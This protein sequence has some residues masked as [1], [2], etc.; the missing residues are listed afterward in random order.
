MEITAQPILSTYTIISRGAAAGSYQAF[1]DA[2]RL[3]NGDIVVVYYAGYT[4]V[5]LPNEEYPRGG[6]ICMVRSQDEGQSW[7]EPEVLYDDEADNRDPHI[8]QLQDGTVICSFFSLRAEP[9]A[10]Y[11]FA[12]LGVQVVRS[13]D[14]GHTWEKNAPLLETENGIWVCSCPVRQLAVGTCLLPIY[15]HIGE[16]AWGG[17]LRSEDGGKTWGKEITIGKE[18]QILMPAETD[19]IELKDG[20][21]Y[22]ALRADQ[23]VGIEMQ[24]SVSVD[25]GLTWSAVQP[26]GFF[27]HAPHFSRLRNG[28]I[29]LTTRG[30]HKAGDVAGYTALQIS[31]DEAHSWHGPYL[32]DPSPGAYTATVELKDGGILIVYYEEGEGSGIRAAR[33]RID[34]NLQP[35]GV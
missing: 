18:A 19:I 15:Q 13:F 33:F 27:G 35:V 9:S 1:P 3:Q 26:I 22:A 4:H 25:R 6:R 28:H 11:G 31:D 2:C 5:S 16:A 30:F 23:E 24:Y 14:G 12:A 17:V 21:L 29:V 8:A 7:S 34:E 20:R 32:L 10:E